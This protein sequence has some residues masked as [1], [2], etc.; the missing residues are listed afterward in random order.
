[1]SRKY[2][3]RPIVGVGVVIFNNQNVLLARRGNP[4]HQNELSLPGGAQKIGETILDAAKRE[5]FEETQLQV[6]IHAI[7]DVVDSIERDPN[8]KVI[9]HYTL[10]DVL[11][12]AVGSTIPIAASDVTEAIWVKLDDISSLT[13]WSETVRIINIAA[14]MRKNFRDFSI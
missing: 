14:Q 13:I 11:A 8:G 3:V 9:Y 10:I 7:I 2:P 4:P 6:K 5:V 1:M 12:S